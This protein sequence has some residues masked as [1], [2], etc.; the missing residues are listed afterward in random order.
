MKALKK[1][2]TTYLI[3]SAVI[4]F[5]SCDTLIKTAGTIIESNA[6]PSI[7]EIS[8]GLRQALSVSVDT[9][10]YRLN[11]VDGYY[12]DQAVKLVLPPET[13]QV[14]EY[15]RRVPGLDTKIEEFV[16]QINRS[17]EDAALAA[18][19]IFKEAITKMDINDATQILQ[20]A[21][22]AASIYLKDKTYSKLVEQYKPL[23]AESL[24]KPLL[25]G[26]S[27]DKSWN[28]ISSLWNRF[29]NS[30]AGDMLKLE[31]VNI[32]LEDYF[33]AKALDG[34]FVKIELQEKEIRN[35]ANARV[36]TLLQKV[37]K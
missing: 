33:T 36:T 32:K 35:N 10:V 16:I 27:A 23:F 9:A 20:G 24:K 26:V 6:T 12:M 37:F 31:P 11:Q 29:A 17:A 14:V 25:A 1:I 13:N 30:F 2:K 4:I 28:D 3:L 22:N 7:T 15:A 34:L 5:T 19:P 21:D 18:A 8:A